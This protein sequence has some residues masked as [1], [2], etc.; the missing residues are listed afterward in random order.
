MTARETNEKIMPP[1][2]RTPNNLCGNQIS[3]A[4]R[5]R[6]DVVLMT[7][8]ARWR[9]DPRHRRDV[10]PVTV[11]V[12]EGLRYPNSDS[13]Q[14]STARTNFERA[15]ETIEGQCF[16]LPPMVCYKTKVAAVQKSSSGL[17]L[18]PLL[19]L[20]AAASGK[21]REKPVRSTPSTPPPRDTP[22]DTKQQLNKASA[23]A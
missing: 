11:E 13:T 17:L 9:G 21:K 1:S 20:N 6:R 23:G 4:P 15:S 16:G 14:Q 22:K 5:H 18:R 8:S 10:V 12:H 19:V 7:A 2:A 3:G